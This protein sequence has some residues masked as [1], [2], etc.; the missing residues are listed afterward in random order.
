[1][2]GGGGRRGPGRRHRVDRHC[3]GGSSI[4]LAMNMPGMGVLLAAELREVDLPEI[5]EAGRGDKSPHR[6]GLAAFASAVVHDGRRG[7][8]RVDEHLRVRDRLPWCETRNRSTAPMRL[9]GHIRSNSL[10]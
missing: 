8:K 5:F 1:M 3:S 9:F 6:V 7:A 4:R 10:F 2:R